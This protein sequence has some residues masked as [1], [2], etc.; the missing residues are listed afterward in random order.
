[1]VS[2]DA[3]HVVT[4]RVAQNFA[5]LVLFENSIRPGIRSRS[6]II[7]SLQRNYQCQHES[8]SNPTP[9]DLYFGSGQTVA[10]ER[11]SIEP[12]NV[13][14]RRLQRRKKAA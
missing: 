12:N 11:E 10:L 14:N 7:A 4:E 5:G 9:T 8:F 13:Q 3:D 6:R 2:A 1:V